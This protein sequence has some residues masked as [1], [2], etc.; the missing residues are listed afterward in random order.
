[1]TLVDSN[2]LLDVLTRDPAWSEWSLGALDAAAI[3]GPLLINDIIYAEISSRFV[4]IEPLDLFVDETGLQI[5]SMP[6]AALFLA[7]KA[8]SRYRAGGGTRTGVLADFFIGAQAAVSG[9]D[10]LTRDIARYR[11]YFPDVKLISPTIS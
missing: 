7:S 2:V 5:T 11:T 3:T 1:L 10:L 8:H 6:R 4:A 9:Y